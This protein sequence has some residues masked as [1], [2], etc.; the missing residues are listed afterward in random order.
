MAGVHDQV[1]MRRA[2]ELAARGLGRTSPNPAV[3]AV[4]VRDGQ[5]VG[6]GRHRL[7]GEPHA[8][9]LALLNAGEQAQDATI[10]VTLEPCSH[11]GR[12]P[13]CT[14]AIIEAGIS[15]VV[16]ACADIDERCAGRADQV[17]G[18]A[19]IDVESGVLAD[20]ATQ[21]NE[22]YFKHKRTKLPFVTLKLASSL[23]G[24][25][26]TRTGDSRWVTGKEAREFVHELRGRSDAVMVGI[27]TVLAD[28]PQLTT[29]DVSGDRRDALRIVVDSLARTPADARVIGPGSHE[30]CLIAV[31][32]SAPEERLAGLVL[33]GAEIMRLPAGPGGHV[34]LNALTAELG[35]RNVMSVLL[36]GGGTLA[37]GAVAAA[38]VDRYLFF[39]APKLVGGHDAP[40]GLG[41]DGVERMADAWQVEITGV[42]RIGADIMIEGVPCSQG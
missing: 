35:R 7:A 38:V 36:E 8:E 33:A 40:T 3:G 19:G 16:Y 22:A 39:Y 26:A 20:E 42:E 4:V 23:D 37:A 27:G 41:G 11:W 2:L 12:T 34:D 30:R 9:P 25:I 15:R 17:L 10:Y 13:P 24:K 31:S 29:R 6:E 18:D 28:D 32:E 1:F 21:L 5:I 14:Q